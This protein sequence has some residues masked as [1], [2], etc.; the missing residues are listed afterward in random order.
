[1]T[2]RSGL[3]DRSLPRV[4]GACWGLALLSLAGCGEARKKERKPPV[5]A[6]VAAPAPASVPPTPVPAPAPA[7]TP[8]TAPA[9]AGLRPQDAKAHGTLVLTLPRT[10]QLGGFSFAATWDPAALSVGEPAT[11][12]AL[13]GYMCQ[14]NVSVPGSLRYD[15]VGLPQDQRG[16]RLAVLPVHHAARPPRADDFAIVKN[17]VVDDMGRTLEGLHIELS[18]APAA[19][20]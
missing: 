16:G 17:D 19:A 8:A 14:A 2:G 13:Q 11:E 12:A 10:V 20:P 18:V 15:C 4:L 6:P 5:P 3:N 1:M 9:P 7:P